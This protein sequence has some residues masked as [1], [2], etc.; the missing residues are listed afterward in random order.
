MEE[1]ESSEGTGSA[2]FGFKRKSVVPAL[3]QNKFKAMIN[4]DEE[5]NTG[6][7][8]KSS[9]LNYAQRSARVHHRVSL[10]KSNLNLD[11]NLNENKNS[12]SKKD[13][14]IQT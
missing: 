11:L 10:A 8:T 5:D 3:D 12:G 13:Y 7:R 9:V 4:L 14:H 2:Q 6:R 1:A